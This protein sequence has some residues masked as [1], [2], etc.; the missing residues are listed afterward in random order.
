ME[1]GYWTEIV[2]AT[3]WERKGSREDVLPGKFKGEREIKRERERGE[4]RKQHLALF[5]S[6]IQ[7]GKRMAKCPAHISTLTGPYPRIGTLHLR[8]TGQPFFR[9]CLQW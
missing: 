2:S 9:F 4:R 5:I 6:L 3:G 7:A 8:A 1:Q